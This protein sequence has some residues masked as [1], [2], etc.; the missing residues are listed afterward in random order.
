MH[1]LNLASVDLNLLTALEVIL[2]ERDMTKAANRLNV[3]QPS[4][5][6]KFTRL[7]E[8]FHDPLL[9][10][11]DMG[12]VLT[13]RAEWLQNQISE[14]MAAIRR[15]YEVPEFEPSR[16]S[17]VV[18]IGSLDYGEIVLLPILEKQLRETAPNIGL[19]VVPRRLRSCSEILQHRA[20]VSIGV[21]PQSMDDMCECEF[22][23]EERYVCL[24]DKHHPL[25]DKELTVDAYIAYEHSIINTPSGQLT[26]AEDV[27]R[28]LGL[29]RSI[30]RSSH[31]FVAALQSLPG[32]ELLLTSGARLAKMFGPTL[33]LV[34]KELPINVDAVEI[35]QIWHVRNTNNV[36]NKWLRDQIEM[37]AKQLNPVESFD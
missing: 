27:L 18:R 37:A 14:P 20:D 33:G 23:F 15:A 31:N 28:S 26:G 4:M 16:E 32:T 34:V 7:R 29:H 9:I 5:S 24:M 21:L 17:G 30:K 8:T 1:N 12:Y 10:R 19:E 2:D 36:R 35:Y 6:R 11:T 13:A 25:A 22:L 3:S